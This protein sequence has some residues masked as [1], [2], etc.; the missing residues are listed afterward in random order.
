[1]CKPWVCPS[2]WA[3]LSTRRHPA[4]PLSLPILHPAEIQALRSPNH[5][6]EILRTRHGVTKM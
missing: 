3:V 5:D 4:H 1:M 2:Y 6:T